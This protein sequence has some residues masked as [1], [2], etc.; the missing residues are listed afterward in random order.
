[1]RMCPVISDESSKTRGDLRQRR[2]LLLAA[3]I[4]AVVLGSA[5]G[6]LTN[7]LQPT[8]VPSPSRP[9]TAPAP[10]TPESR[11]AAYLAA[12]AAGDHRAALEA[13]PAPQL[14][15][16]NNDRRVERTRELAGLRI[17]RAYTVTR[18]SYQFKEMTAETER[19]ATFAT[20]ILDAADQTGR[21][22]PLEL[23]VSRAIPSSP[24]FLGDMGGE[25]TLL[26]VHHV[27][28]CTELGC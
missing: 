16:F 1:M 21:V 13:W 3:A 11:V 4:A 24:S 27:H 14:Q 9:L 23:F 22:Y 5:V 25:W 18:V 10:A 12:T 20:V 6:S 8:T 26:D 17:G 28:E 19:D 7:G 2:F 15:G